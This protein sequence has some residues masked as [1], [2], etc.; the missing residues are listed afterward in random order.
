MSVMNEREEDAGWD[1][2][3]AQA[4]NWVIYLCC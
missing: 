3:S 2:Y 4:I 1:N